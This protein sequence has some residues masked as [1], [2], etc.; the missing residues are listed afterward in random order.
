MSH[1]ISPPPRLLPLASQ[2]LNR[3]DE[4]RKAL[5]NSSEPIKAIAY[6]YGYSDPSCFVRA[7]RVQFG[8]TPSKYRKTRNE[9]SG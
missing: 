5:A 3:L 7:F 6:N 9:V 8:F 4:A 2:R 1:K